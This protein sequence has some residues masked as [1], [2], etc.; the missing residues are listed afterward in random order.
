[1]EH[2]SDPFARTTLN[3][4]FI[5][6][7]LALEQL[8]NISDRRLDHIASLYSKDVFK[9]VERQLKQFDSKLVSTDDCVEMQYPLVSAEG[10]PVACQ[11]RLWKQRDLMYWHFQ[12]VTLL[13]KE[14]LR[15]E[16]F[17]DLSPI[18]LS[19]SLMPE[20]RFV[21][22]NKAFVDLFGYIV[23]EII[24]RSTSELGLI[25][26]EQDALAIS[27]GL[28]AHRYVN[29]LEVSARTKDGRILEG[30]FSASIFKSKGKEWMEAAFVDITHRKGI[31]KELN[32]ERKIA[33]ELAAK[34]ELANKTKDEFLANISH[35]LRTPLNGIIGMTGLLLK[36]ELDSKQRRFTELLRKSGDHL[37]KIIDGLLDYQR[38]ELGIN[39]LTLKP[40]NL[41]RLVNDIAD[42][43]RELARDRKLGFNVKIDDSIQE[44]LIGDSAKIKQIIENFL[45]NAINFSEKGAITLS[46]YREA[47]TSKGYLLNL[48]VED[49]GIG[50]A[51]SDQKRIFDKFVQLDTSLTRKNGMGIGLSLCQTLA[52]VMDGEIEVKSKVGKGS[53]FS[54]KF[55]VACDAENEATLTSKEH[56]VIQSFSDGRFIRVL[57]AEDNITNQQVMLGLLSAISVEADVVSNGKLALDVLKKTPYDLLLLDLQ[58][59]ELNGLEVSRQIRDGALGW[60]KDIPIIAMTAHAQSRAQMICE[61]AGMDGFIAKPFTAEKLAEVI[62]LSINKKSYPAVLDFEGLVARM[63]DNETLAVRIASTLGS[64]L[65]RLIQDVEKATKSNDRESIHRAAHTLKG[66]CLSGGANRL[67]QIAKWLEESARTEKNDDIYLQGNQLLESA[68]LHLNQYILALSRK[69]VGDV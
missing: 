46:A 58:M 59:P 18:A 45:L 23:P 53:T 54:L 43:Y 14:Q 27:E 69:V 13:R 2:S 41:A 36:G 10:Y 9:L 55:E 56:S 47:I 62:L 16:H 5:D 34:A 37:L 49:Q 7:N 17:W 21:K 67:A 6:Y 29:N 28:R 38:I 8:C 19:L 48:S 11:I 32:D 1:M 26:D 25:G 33:Q 20:R 51:K 57:V 68:S 22:V 44:L 65:P 15:N 35:E 31:E 4:V 42:P 40:F 60:T 39:T 63:L 61:Q 52:D 3:G 24:G 64:E 66:A 30:L 50:I 12:P